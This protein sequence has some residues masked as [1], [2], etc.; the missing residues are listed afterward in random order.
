MKENHG[1]DDDCALVGSVADSI[2]WIPEG[3]DGCGF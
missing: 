2:K 1:N 3:Q